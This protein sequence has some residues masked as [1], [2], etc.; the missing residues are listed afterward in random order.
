MRRHKTPRRWGQWGSNVIGVCLNIVTLSTQTTMARLFPTTPQQTPQSFLMKHHSS[1]VLFCSPV[2]ACGV[3]TS[4][5]YRCTLPRPCSPRAL[6]TIRLATAQSVLGRSFTGWMN[7]RKQHRNNHLIPILHNTERLQDS[8]KIQ[9]LLLNIFPTQQAR[10]YRAPISFV[11]RLPAR[12]M[13]LP[14]ALLLP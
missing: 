11:N 9:M 3:F 1:L 6:V 13:A 7:S 8:N 2:L 10:S 4:L 12:L 5:Q 14:M